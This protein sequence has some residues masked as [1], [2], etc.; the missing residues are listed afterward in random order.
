MTLSGK[1]LAAD[2]TISDLSRQVERLQEEKNKYE[3][4]LE[5]AREEVC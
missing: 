3:T 4:L 1:N 2:S 5:A